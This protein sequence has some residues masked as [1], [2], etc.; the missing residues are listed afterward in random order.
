MKRLL[1]SI[2]ALTLVLALPLA[3][4]AQTPS[5]WA[6]EEVS[7]AIELELV[8]E[9]LQADYQAPITREEFCTLVM[10]LWSLFGDETD[11]I[12][13][14]ENPFSDTDNP[15]VLA[16]YELGIVTG[17][18][19]SIFDPSG[20]ILRQESAAM[21]A[22][23]VQA[24]GIDTAHAPAAA[25]ADGNQIA[26]YAIYPINF[27]AEKEIMTGVG[28]NR[29]SP[30]GTY[31][32]EQSILTMVRL[33][34]V[35]NSELD[36]SVPTE[37]SDEVPD[38]VQEVKETV[39]GLAEKYGKQLDGEWGDLHAA[40]IE[41]EEGEDFES[42][43]TMK[44]VLDEIRIESGAYYFYAFYPSGDPASSD[45]YI[46]V[47]GSED[48]DEY[49]A[50]YHWEI[51]FTEA[52]NGTPAPARS[53]WDNGDDDPVWSAFAPIHD[54]DGNVVAILGIDFPA[55]SILEYPEWNRDSEVWNGITE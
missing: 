4:F 32:R 8:P 10:V 36:I 16:A 33:Y 9:A 52:W 13:A 49:G 37:V 39:T 11:D 18:S 50:L 12:P 1:A 27:V 40:L 26:S 6:T 30:T 21:L 5:G 3:A 54:S 55:P 31:T 24:L 53:A 41:S 15:S 22:R 51:Q 45:Y 46:T 43:E 35:L 47:D 34:D 29:F 23:T 14:G 2:L 42:F 20:S 7:M 44:A 38:E 19:D 48:P 28:D 25:F 17:K